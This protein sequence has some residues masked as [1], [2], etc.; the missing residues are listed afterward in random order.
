MASR[1][2]RQNSH[3]LAE[4]ADERRRRPVGAVARAPPLPHAAA[5]ATRRIARHAERQPEIVLA[6][7][8]PAFARSYMKDRLA[9]DIPA[10]V[11]VSPD[12]SIAG[13]LQKTML[14]KISDVIFEQHETR[15][16]AG[17]I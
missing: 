3:A 14:C 4:A 11:P 7:D 10:I 12:K 5:R 13:I 6:Q 2:E 1:V 15:A 16:P 8:V 17:K 9:G